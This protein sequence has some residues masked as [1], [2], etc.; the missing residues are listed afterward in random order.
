M[1]NC[2]DCDQPLRPYFTKRG[3]CQH[4]CYD[5]RHRAGTHVDAP[6]TYRSRAD[7]LDDWRV[8]SGEG[9]TRAQAAPRMGMTKTALDRALWRA[10]RAGV[11]A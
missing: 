2:H 6:T 9:C 8:L 3:L 4:P 7:V 5:R 1:N 10:Q 11:T